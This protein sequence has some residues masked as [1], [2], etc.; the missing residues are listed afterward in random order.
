MESV[1]PVAV[2]IPWF[3]RDLTG[4]AEQYA[5]QIAVRLRAHG[6][7]VEVLTTCCRSFLE[8]WSTNYFTAGVTEEEGVTVRRF[9]VIARDKASFDQV[10]ARMLNLSAAS[11]K[12]GIAPV[13]G[14]DSRPVYQG[15]YQLVGVVRVSAGSE[16]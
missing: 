4:G 7:P 11:L 3:G 5:W 9:P 8:D 14:E 10:N 6:H 1:R 2:V 16:E 13:S 12:P 15:E